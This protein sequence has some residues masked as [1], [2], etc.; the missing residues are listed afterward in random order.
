MIF[1]V[2]VSPVDGAEKTAHIK[3]ADISRANMDRGPLSL[4][5][6]KFEAGVMSTDYSPRCV[7]LLLDWAVFVE[8]RFR[9]GRI[10]GPHRA[11]RAKLE[12][13]SRLA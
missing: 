9:E 11:E 6:A 13:D 3:T 7:G 4:R 1:V 10:V 12:I 2:D 8:R 5:T